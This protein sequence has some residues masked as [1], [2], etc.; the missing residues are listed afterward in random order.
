[1]KKYLNTKTNIG[2]RCYHYNSQ[3]LKSYIT[4]LICR[5]E[6][7]ANDA[8]ILAKLQVMRQQDSVLER[9]GRLPHTGNRLSQPTT[10][11]K[12]LF[13]RRGSLNL[14]RL[15]E[16]TETGSCDSS[17]ENLGGSSTDGTGSC[18]DLAQTKRSKIL[19]SLSN[20]MNK[21]GSDMWTRREVKP[22]GKS[23][24]ESLNKSPI[25]SPSRTPVTENDP[26]GALM[27]EVEEIEKRTEETHKTV[28]RVG[29][30]IELDQSGAPVSR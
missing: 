1:M 13:R 12:S 9:N 29:S 30:E 8:G 3:L 5:S 20:K 14:R 22:R 28:S 26:L 11:S 17:T 10:V 27:S 25:K 23:S 24:S 15:K 2:E 16:S 18:D 7:F 21:I 4:Y 19:S 6:S